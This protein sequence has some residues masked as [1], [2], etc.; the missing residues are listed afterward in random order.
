MDFY[1]PDGQLSTSGFVRVSTILSVRD[2]PG[3]NA[4]K[5]RV[6]EEESTRISREAT[7]LGTQ[8]HRGIEALLKTGEL[9]SWF[10]ERPKLEDPAAVDTSNVR[11]AA[12]LFRGFLSWYDDAAPTDAQSEQFLFHKKHQYAG[13]TD[14]I[15]KLNGELYI[16]DFKTSKQ[17]SPEMGLQLV[18]Y[19]EAY[20]DMHGVRPRTAILQFTRGVKSGYRFELFDSPFEIFLACKAIYDWEVAVGERHIP[21]GGGPIHAK[22]KK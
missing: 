13:T 3:L 2:K 4:W 18:A 10:T 19:R 9:P 20:Y 11:D 12:N 15:C 1:S 6:G 16:V 14:L 17:I 5:L 7:D 21:Y 22:I 8:V